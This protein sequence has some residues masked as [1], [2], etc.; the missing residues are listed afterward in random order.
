MLNQCQSYNAKLV[1]AIQCTNPKTTMRI[2]TTTDTWPFANPSN[3]NSLLF[4]SLSNAS[5]EPTFTQTVIGQHLLKEWQSSETSSAW[6]FQYD[7]F[8]LVF[9]AGEILASQCQAPSK[10]YPEEMLLP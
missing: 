8:D 7:L 5:L 10:F 4:Q 6:L 2:N 1:V 3:K 9:V